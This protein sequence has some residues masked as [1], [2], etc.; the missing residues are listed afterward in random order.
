MDA[1]LQA[2]VDQVAATRGVVA[3]TTVALQGVIVR[4]DALIADEEEEGNDT[5][6]LEQLRADLA[7]VTPA[8]ANAVAAIPPKSPVEP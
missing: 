4:L 6:Q 3:S 5:A 8:L 1:T 7:E 2:L